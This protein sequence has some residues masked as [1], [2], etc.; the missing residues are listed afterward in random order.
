MTALAEQEA[1]DA[2]ARARLYREERARR[3]A[4][5]AQ[6]RASLAGD[7]AAWLAHH[8]A[9]APLVD[10]LAERQEPGVPSEFEL[11]PFGISEQVNVGR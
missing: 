8:E 7:H 2:E 11:D 9:W 6:L 3:I 1:A 10:W 5:Q 4:F